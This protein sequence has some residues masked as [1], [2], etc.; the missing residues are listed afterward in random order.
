MIEHITNRGSQCRLTTSAAL[1][2]PSDEKEANY[3]NSDRGTNSRILVAA[4]AAASAAPTNFCD[5]FGGD[6]L[7]PSLSLQQI[8]LPLLS[9]SERGSR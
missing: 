4:A 1:S 2:L 7:Q 3:S 6:I 5:A 9:S 8:A